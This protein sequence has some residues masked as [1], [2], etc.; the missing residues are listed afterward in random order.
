MGGDE[1]RERLEELTRRWRARQDDR[2]RERAVD[3]SQREAADPARL[4]RARSLLP[5]REVA[6]DA[7][8]AEHGAAM[9]AYTYDDYA[10][11]DPELQAW[12]D[13]VGRLLRAGPMAPNR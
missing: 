1:R 6:P 5:Y 3:G 13:E 8:V 2:R 4:E 11:P 12:I 10:Y 9:G 7:Y